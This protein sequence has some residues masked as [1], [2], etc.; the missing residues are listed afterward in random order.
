LII[1][2]GTQLKTLGF[3]VPIMTMKSNTVN[4]IWTSGHGVRPAALAVGMSIVA[5][6]AC[7]GLNA[8]NDAPSTKADATTMAVDAAKDAAPVDGAAQVNCDPLGRFGPWVALGTELPTGKN[9]LFGG[10]PSSDELTFY[11]SANVSTPEDYNI[12]VRRRATKSAAFGPPVLLAAQNTNAYDGDPSISADGLS[13]WSVTKRASN[14]QMYVATRANLLAEFAAPGLALS[15]NA[16]GNSAQ[17]FVTADNKELWF[18]SDRSGQFKIWNAQVI[19]SG[20]LDPELASTLNSDAI[21]WLPRLSADKLT[22]YIASNRAG[23]L[24]GFDVLRS[25][26]TTVNDGFPRPTP[27]VELNTSGDDF[28]SWI[29][30][31]NCRAYGQSKGV[32]S[33][34]TRQP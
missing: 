28:V 30:P 19:A 22:V 10:Q 3:I 16:A 4:G 8:S 2:L 29:S 1:L 21:D 23:G 9:A 20:F 34:A 33:I 26:R 15:V 27:V 7:G 12:Y 5:L 13:L 25:H 32:T 24:G 14:Y 31:D 18:S 17:P 6:S 11:F